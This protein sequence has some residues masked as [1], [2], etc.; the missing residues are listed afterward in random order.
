[1]TKC[2]FPNM[3]NKKDEIVYKVKASPFFWRQK[4]EELK[5]ASDVIWPCIKKRQNKIYESLADKTTINFNDLEPD[6]FS[7]FLSLIGFSTECLFKGIAIRNNPAYVSNGKLINKLRSHN[8]IKLAEIAKI[9]LSQ[10]EEI[11]CKQAYKAMT[12]DS[13][14]PIPKEVDTSDSSMEIGGHCKDVFNELYDKLYPT[15]EQIG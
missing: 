5:F 1:M 9:P 7:I 3:F 11:F 6:I 10:H 15:L 14:Y 8:L 13:R 2:F 4:A 12:I